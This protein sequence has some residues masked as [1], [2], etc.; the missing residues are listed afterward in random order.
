MLHH[1][2]QF[3]GLA[4]PSN[5]GLQFSEP[6]S[7]IEITSPIVSTCGEESVSPEGSN[8]S[9]SPFSVERGN[10]DDSRME[11]H[12]PPQ[13]ESDTEEE[14]R[15]E[16]GG[17][18]GGGGGGE[19]FDSDER[20]DERERVERQERRERERKD[21]KSRDVH[22][23]EE[24]NREKRERG[25]EGAERREGG[26][27]E[28]REDTPIMKDETEWCV[29]AA[30]IIERNILVDASTSTEEGSGM[31]IVPHI[32]EFFVHWY[33]YDIDKIFDTS[34]INFHSVQILLL[35]QVME[36]E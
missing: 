1:M 7:P 20:S 31:F 25:G 13:S 12:R 36:I 24:G 33:P 23:D 35:P 32:R 8:R 11:S 19:S 10:Y 4:R 34:S 18:G 14:E 2:M 27:A 29:D 15:N 16:Q 30:D 5:S 3:Q 17:G 22:V 26:Q 21:V 28:R 9:H 6:N